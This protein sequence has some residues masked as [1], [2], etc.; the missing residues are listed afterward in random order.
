MKRVINPT[1]KIE[2]VEQDGLYS[3]TD[4]W[5]QSGLGEEKKPA[6]WLKT[7]T[8][9]EFINHISRSEYIHFDQIVETMRG[10]KNQGSYAH[11]QIALAYAKY[12]SPELHARVNQ[13]FKERLENDRKEDFETRTAKLVD[14]SLIATKYIADDL[15][16]NEASKILMYERCL[17]ALGHSAAVAALPSYTE[18]KITKP[19][20]DLLKDFG[21]DLSAKAANKI[22]LQTGIL[23]E[24]ERRGSKGVIKKYK[25][26]TEEGLKF[27]KNLINPR[28]QKETQPHYFADTFQAIIEHLILTVDT[29]ESVN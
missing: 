13:V 14:P 17:T 1:N 27:G 8:A 20:T 26:L 4:I 28:N 15:R 24:K 12:L 2:L 18:E 9:K 5:K 10:G 23:E 11:W 22:L 29:V 25:S 6:Q 19:I 7:D 21:I 16:V 3:L